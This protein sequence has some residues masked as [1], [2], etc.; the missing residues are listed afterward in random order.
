MSARPVII[1][2]AA[3]GASETANRIVG[4][5][6]EPIVSPVSR[7]IE[8]GEAFETDAD[9]LAFTSANGARAVARLE[10]ARDRP[11]FTVGDATAEAAR[12][13]GFIDI[14]SANGDVD[15]LARL[16]IDALP[17][18][19]RVLHIGG[20][21]MAGDLTGQLGAAGLRAAR[22]VVYR[23]E[24]AS[25]LSGAAVAALKAGGA[26]V[27]IHSPRGARLFSALADGAG[28][29]LDRTGFAAISQAAAEPLARRGLMV[30]AASSPDEA[31]LLAALRRAARN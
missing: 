12:G 24:P 11:V 5:G 6:F 18:G 27:L 15:A 4:L 17:K 13:A 8:T 14:R 26:L 30:E 19:A 9:A 16:L 21:D 28:L 23:A 10:I 31:G 29:S 7:I 1:T 20:E 25:S 2:R 22:A 3:P